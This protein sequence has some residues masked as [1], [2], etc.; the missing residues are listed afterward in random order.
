[1]REPGS[2]RWAAEEFGRAEIADKR[3]R[4][5]LVMVAARVARRPAGHVTATITHAAERQGAYGL[6]ESPGVKVAELA[7]GMSQGCARRCAA[8]R[9]VLCAIDG[10]S[11]TLEDC[12]EARGLG[13]IGNRSKRG[14]GLKVMTALVLSSE[15]VPLGISAQQW[16][17]RSERRRLKHRDQL[18]ASHK[19]TQR[20]I[21][22]IEQTAQ[23]LAEHAP[24]TRCWF[25][26]DREGDAWPILAAARGSGHWF[27]IRAR[28]NRR[29]IVDGKRRSKL[30]SVVAS[31]P[32]L[33]KYEL[34]VPGTTKRRA[35]HT[36]MVARACTVTLD[37]RDKRDGRRFPM[38]VNVVQAREQGT[39]PAG[40]KP[41]EWTLLTSHP[42]TSAED[43]RAVIFG[44]SMRWR[45][46]ELHRTWKSG[47]CCI[48]QTQLR[49]ATA[50]MKWGT[51]L[52]AVA[53][54]IERIKQLARNQPDQPA[55][56]EF[57]AA[58]IQA[59]HLLRFEK[60][61]QLSAGTRSVPTIHEVTLWIAQVG[62]Y[63]GK[64]SGGPPGSV[65][66]AR[67]LDRVST[68]ARALEALK[69]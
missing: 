52:A 19:E 37:I 39:T 26:L 23:V 55:T 12:D 40:E 48:E 24:A 3:W 8:E 31:Q 67:G 34:T 7:G 68:T 10:S 42:I 43:A 28:G 1:M 33:T 53:V 44:Y 5:R 21:D 59:A 30:R 15:G 20:W 65:T 45:I 13:P 2:D 36:Q 62:G 47:A 11:V 6:L 64:S 49:S 25:Q 57:T 63:T 61:L 54:R 27:T 22:A 58:E 9:V 60:P 69:M 18:C 29:V 56:E 4:R 14:R 16:W 41:I 35:R 66:L 51:I 50:I 38:T 17:R 46:E 32:V